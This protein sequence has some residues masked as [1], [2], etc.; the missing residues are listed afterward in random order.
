MTARPTK[1]SPM[2]SP[3]GKGMLHAQTDEQ[4]SESAALKRYLADVQEARQH[5]KEQ[6][7]ISPSKARIDPKQEKLNASHVDPK[8][9][10]LNSTGLLNAV[11]AATYP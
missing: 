11:R 5:E 8:R 9:S 6:T 1:A 3:N 7:P 10:G 4:V 2:I